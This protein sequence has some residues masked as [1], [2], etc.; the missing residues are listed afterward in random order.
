M[1]PNEALK[2][3]REALIAFHAEEDSTLIEEAA[4]RLADAFEALDEWLM[5]GGFMPE[6]WERAHEERARVIRPNTALV[7][8]A[9]E[10]Q[11][12]ADDE[13]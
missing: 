1:D 6:A 11:A 10:G 9:R 7:D 2:N 3:A 13:V 12:L 4:G 5:K 8:A